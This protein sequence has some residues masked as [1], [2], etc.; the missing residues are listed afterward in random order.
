M[1][2]N[3]Q[4]ETESEKGERDKSQLV[5]FNLIR[6]WGIEHAVYCVQIRKR[7][8]DWGS[9]TAPSKLT[10]IFIRMQQ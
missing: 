6:L 10:F 4:K 9:H 2:E 1:R 5:G 3:I 7:M 8:K